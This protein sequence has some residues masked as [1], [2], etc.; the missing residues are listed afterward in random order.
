M[1]LLSSLGGFIMGYDCG[2]IVDVVPRVTN[3]VK[4]FSRLWVFETV[5]CGPHV[6][7]L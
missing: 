5:G 1:T 7:G 6:V 2:V 4:T 3:L